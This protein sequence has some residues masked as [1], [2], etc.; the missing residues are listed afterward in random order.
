MLSAFDQFESK[1]YQGP[2]ERANAI[3]LSGERELLSAQSM[4]QHAK[5]LR[6]ALRY[7]TTV[8]ISPSKVTANDFRTQG[9]ARTQ[10][11]RK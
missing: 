6:A 10:A 2:R 5:K 7:D 4:H 9:S 3:A 8:L 1:H 11:A